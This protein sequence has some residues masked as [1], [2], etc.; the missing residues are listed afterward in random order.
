MSEF[1]KAEDFEGRSVVHASDGSPAVFT[2]DAARIA[3][4]ILKERGTVVWSPNELNWYPE[5]GP[6]AKYQA[7]V[8]NIEEMTSKECE[9]SPGLDSNWKNI[10]GYHCTICGIKLKPG[11]WTK[12]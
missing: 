9:H 11:S 10:L 5:T 6:L 8:V 2:G 7:I 3:N 4:R 12:A 1:F